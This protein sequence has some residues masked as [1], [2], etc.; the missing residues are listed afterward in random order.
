[1]TYDLL[2]NEHKMY[3]MVIKFPQW[4]K[5]SPNGLKILKHFPISGPPKLTQFGIF[6]LKRNHLAILFASP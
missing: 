3:Q 5:N 2:T 1:V 6:G 4:L